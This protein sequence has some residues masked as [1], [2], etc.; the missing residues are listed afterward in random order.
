MTTWKLVGESTFKKVEEREPTA[1]RLVGDVSALLV[2]LS[3][4]IPKPLERYLVYNDASKIILLWQALVAQCED[5]ERPA[6]VAFPETDK[7]LAGYYTAPDGS[8]VDRFPWQADPADPTATLE[9][10]PENW[11]ALVSTWYMSQVW[12][13]QRDLVVAFGEAMEAIT[14]LPLERSA[15][16]LHQWLSIE[17]SGEAVSASKPASTSK[18]RTTP[19][20]SGPRRTTASPAA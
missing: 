13:Q 15:P 18:G 11:A 9:G 2:P 3:W 4:P 5:A 8:P 12:F 20:K 7:E 1:Y 19:R 14:G 10:R 17:P 6:Y 16:L